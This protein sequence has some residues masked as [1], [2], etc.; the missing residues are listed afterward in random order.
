M[1]FTKTSLAIFAAMAMSTNA[2]TVG[3]S[4]RSSR[5]LS[6]IAATT[7][8]ADNF[9]FMDDAETESP[10]STVT[11]VMATRVL[12][13]EDTAEAAAVVAPKKKAVPKK[14]A[15]HGKEGVF[16]PVVKTVKAVM[17]DAELNKLR[18]KVIGLHSEVI[19]NFVN[20]SD[21]PFGK[22]VLKQMYAAFDADRNG[23][24]EESELEALLLTLGFSHLNAKQIHGIFER[25]DADHDGHITE[26]E[27]MNEAPKTLRTNLIKLAKKN[28]GDMGLL[29]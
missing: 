25:A 22:K 7:T 12:A 21:T 10:A 19:G 8:N 16:S 26:E 6:S 4:M 27:W 15:A 17:G 18:G 29:A 11:P 3:P 14:S 2:F 9:H 13:T 20:T 24:L 1:M 28:G 23:T 5:G